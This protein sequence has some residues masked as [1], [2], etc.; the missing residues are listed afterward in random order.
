MI[1]LLAL[2]LALMLG[3]YIWARIVGSRQRRRAEAA[4]AKID[5]TRQE[6][7]R[8]VAEAIEVNKSVLATMERSLAVEGEAGRQENER[9]RLHWQTE[10]DR[11]QIESNRALEDAR[12]QLEQFS[13]LRELA[14]RE[15]DARAALVAALQ[16]AEELRQQARQFR[17]ETEAKVAVER[18]AALQKAKAARDQA[19]VMLVRATNEA[20]RLVAEA[21]RKAEAIAGDAY[22]ALREKDHLGEAIKAVRNVIDGYGDRYI[23]PTRS[24]LDDLAADFG[25][26]EAGRALAAAREHS[27][28][29]VEQNLAATCDYAERNRRE[30]AVR[31]VIDAFN[32]RVDGILS[33]TK[34]DNFGTLEQEIRDVFSLV[35]LNGEA[36]RNA[37]VLPDFLDAR[38]AELRW[39]VVAQEL[40]LREREEQRRIREQIREEERA[41][42]EYERAIKEAQK[43]EDILKRAL[44]TARREAEVA[45]AGQRERLEQQMAELAQR[46]AE[47][48]A[49]NQR[50]LSMAQQT[51][52]GNVY[53]ISN[54]GSFGEGI[55]KIGMTRRLEPMER[56]HELGDASVPFEF[57]VHA[58][59]PSD[60][61]PALEA[62]LH[63]TFDDLRLNQVNLRKEFFRVPLDRVR[64]FVSEKGIEA[65][66]TM[67]A[68]AH[69]F[70][71]SQ[72]LAR[73][74]PAERALRRTGRVRSTVM[75][76]LDV[77]PE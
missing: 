42:R 49:K 37:R 15:T 34:H 57:D 23:V 39:A 60:D 6:A 12:R 66:F 19:E 36:F 58:I 51:R 62:E 69:E 27:R 41:R 5:A 64:S 31:F 26:T 10:A 52:K 21:H 45:T 28:R 40:R 29:M 16:E 43:E 4:E 61:A 22:V 35:N 67:A 14:D 53:I 70:R 48:E 11:I 2:A 47:A 18:N 46:L 59:I 9:I 38:L 75:Q 76:D 56:V 65:S 63:S 17:E 55:F 68:E 25:H 54:L 1:N 74:S 72:A 24:L 50:A 7:E 3:L 8:R 13:S 73:L 32:G 33:R 71:E 20:G 44:E 77:Q 30:T